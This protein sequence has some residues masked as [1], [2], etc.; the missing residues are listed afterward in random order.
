MPL[1][2]ESQTRGD[3]VSFSNGQDKKATQIGNMFVSVSTSDTGMRVKAKN[4]PTRLKLP[5][6]LRTH[7]VLGFQRT[8]RAP[9]AR[10]NV[11]AKTSA[12]LARDRAITCHAQ[13]EPNA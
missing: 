9:P 13:R 10:A 5:A 3:G 2:T 1:A 7:N 12:K 4:V 6:I 8:N 11:A